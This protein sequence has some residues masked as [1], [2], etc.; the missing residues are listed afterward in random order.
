[1]VHEPSGIMAEVSDRSRASRRLKDRML[2]EGRGAG[3]PL[4]DRALALDPDVI[5]HERQRLVQREDGDQ[6]GHVAQGDRFVERHTDASGRE[7]PQVDVAHPGSIEQAGHGPAFHL[8]ADGVEEIFVNQPVPQPA[9]RVGQDHRSGVHPFR[10]AAEP[11]R[12]V[13]H[14]VHAR[15]HREQ[16]LGGAHV[17]G[18]LVPPDVLLPGL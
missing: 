4:R 11:G 12:P 18:C 9:Q 1:M 6:V 17:A 16:H 13:I 5:Q 14:G 2:H 8:D 3:E 7:L 15:H 10:N